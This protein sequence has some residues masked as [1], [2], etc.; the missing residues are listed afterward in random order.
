ML[1]KKLRKIFLLCLSVSCF[2]LVFDLAVTSSDVAGNEKNRLVTITVD[3]SKKI[4]RLPYLFRSGSFHWHLPEPDSIRAFE[5]FL[6]DQ[7]VGSIA[8]K[9][10]T[11]LE[12]SK[13]YEDFVKKLSIWDS[14]VKKIVAHG[15]EVVFEI[16]SMPLWLT[17]NP[18]QR[19]D[20]DTYESKNVAFKSPPREYEEWARIVFAIVDH[21]NNGLEIDARYQV[22]AE[23]DIHW[24]GSE[25][26]YLKLYKYSVKGA[27]K[28]D[29]K[30]RIGGPA[31][32]GWDAR[33]LRVKSDLSDKSMIYN[34]IRYC[35][36]TSIPELGLSRLPIDF[37]VW[38]QYNMNP[39]SPSAFARPVKIIRKWLKEFDFKEKTELLIGEWNS[40]QEIGKEHPYFSPEHDT[41]FT[42]SYIIAILDAMHRHGIDRHVFSTL[43]EFGSP[44]RE[45]VGNFGMFTKRKII[46]PAYNAFRLISML[47]ADLIETEVDDD[48]NIA[49]GTREGGNIALLISNFFPDGKML[50]SAVFSRK[51][52]KLPEI[53]HQYEPEE[54]KRAGLTK[55]IL[56]KLLTEEINVDDVNIPTQMKKD[57]RI[58]I[59]YLHKYQRNAKYEKWR[60]RN[61]IRIQINFKHLFYEENFQYQRYLIDSR[62]SNSYAVRAKVES[63]LK[64]GKE[65]E[66]VNE[67]PEV[68]L[69][70]VELKM[71]KPSQDYTIN[72]A[73]EPYSV[74]LI[75]LSK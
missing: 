28:A 67:W 56:R 43:F 38:H 12:A 7:K 25:G 31:T 19:P 61:P 63:A 15:G 21:F 5:K 11:V 35:S 17:K 14:T 68:R 41:E 59:S 50:Q 23:P 71:V 37:I 55:E 64:Q 57:I 26:E 36:E 27:R 65:A 44:D 75:M 2:L 6:S 1:N 30:A 8:I 9:L 24:L 70:P 13:N 60:T 53:E 69:E 54:V 22:W 3:A 74:T 52:T 10:D 48:F 32:T 73:M 58:L 33:S 4:G 49:I 16:W 39:F 72:F 42:A 18:S 29:A 46:K 47:G 40:W 20:L 45:F 62:H 34:F 51:A 66:V